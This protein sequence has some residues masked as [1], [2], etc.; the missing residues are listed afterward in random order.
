[1]HGAEDVFEALAD[2]GDLRVGHAA[3]AGNVA[4]AKGVE[5]EI[6]A[7]A[8]AAAEGGV[9]FVAG[10]GADGAVLVVAVDEGEAADVG[11]AGHAGRLGRGLAGTPALR[12][13]RGDA[14]VEHGAG[15][16]GRRKGIEGELGDLA[17]AG[18]AGGGTGVERKGADIAVALGDVPAGG[19]IERHPVATVVDVSRGRQAGV[20]GLGG[21]AELGLDDDG[22]E[23]EEGRGKHSRAHTSIVPW[24]RRSRGGSA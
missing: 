18:V 10:F 20:T 15:E 11:A 22:G 13:V 23:Q 19:Q 6:E 24:E 7:K 1:M 5:D 3:Y 8:G 12:G 21:C 14:E 4:A 2:G 9:D 17:H 16:G